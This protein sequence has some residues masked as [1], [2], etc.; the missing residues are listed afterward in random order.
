[1]GSII[2]G[3]H[4]QGWGIEKS[5][6]TELDWWQGHKV[7]GLEFVATPA[8]HFSGRS[9]NDRNKTLW[10]SWVIKSGD[11]KVF[12]SGDSG[13]DKHFKEIG[14]KY[15]PFDLAFIENGQ[16]NKAWEEVHLLPEQGIQAF[17][18]LKAK[19]FFPVHWG[20]FKLSIHPW[21]E[22]INKVYQSSLEKKFHLIAPRIG[23]VVEVGMDYKLVNWWE[24][25]MRKGP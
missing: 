13:Y 10:A 23:E 12:F 24:E 16:Y 21:Y 7:K 17:Y 1:M 2:V 22:P 15:G 4:I 3:A 18:D 8:Q 11:K 19:I 14:D 6:I 25:Q 5:R 9:F 20:V